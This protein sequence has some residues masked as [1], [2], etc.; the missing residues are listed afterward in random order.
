MKVIIGESSEIEKLVDDGSIF[1]KEISISLMHNKISDALS[2][3][4]RLNFYGIKK[5]CFHTMK[6]EVVREITK[7][8]IINRPTLIYCSIPIKATIFLFSKCVFFQKVYG[9]ICGDKKFLIR[10]R[11]WQK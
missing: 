11:K 8:L 10:R 2:I 4:Y 1:E 6:Y 3:I 7:D 9:R 5:F